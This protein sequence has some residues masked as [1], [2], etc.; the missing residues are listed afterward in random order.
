MEVPSAYDEVIAHLQQIQRDPSTA[1]D[2]TILDKLKLELTES[3]DR[4]VPATLLTQISQLL[5]IL[6]ED[7]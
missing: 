3:T 1:L 5:P 2:Q 4:K 6:Q 7:S